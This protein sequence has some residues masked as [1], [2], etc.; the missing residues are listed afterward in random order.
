MNFSSCDV[1]ILSKDASSHLLD[2]VKMQ[3][4]CF[5]IF[6][7]PLKFE[8]VRPS[9]THHSQFV[10]SLQKLQREKKAFLIGV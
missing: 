7:H 8:A 2:A 6:L 5:C 9:R 10:T 1:Q 3:K 4:S